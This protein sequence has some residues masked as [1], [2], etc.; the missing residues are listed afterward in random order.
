MHALLKSGLAVLV[1][2]LPLDPLPAQAGG[3]GGDRE[4]MP[5]RATSLE[6]HGI[7]WQ[8]AE[9]HVVGCFANGDPWVVGPVR[10]VAIE[11]SCVEVEGRVLHGSMVDPDPASML[12]GYDSCLFADEHRERYREELNAA[13]GISAE[14][15]LG[16]R[17]GQSLVSV[18]SRADRKAIP[19]LQGAAV[20]T[21]VATPPAPD[22]FRPP[23]VKGDKLM[24]HRAADLD[25]DV[26]RRLRPTLDA[27]PVES[28]AAGFERLW[29]DHF[30]NWPVRYAHPADN[31]PDY[32]REMAALVGSAGLLLNCDLPEQQKR[33]LLVRVVQ[34]GIDLHGALRGGCRW[35]GSGGHGSGRKFPIL[36]AG[37]VLHDG[38]ML[39][40]GREFRS[41]RRSA[42]EGDQY[43]A[44]DGQT[45]TVQETSPGVFNWGFGG[46]TVAHAGLPEWGFAH[47]D[48]PSG[49]RAEWGVDPYRRCC[50]ANGW[51]GQALA[52]RAMGLQEA[53][54]HP[55]FFDY[56]DRYMQVKHSDGWHRAWVPWHATMWDVHRPQH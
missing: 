34:L 30:P 52:A 2:A 1:W 46:Y 20:L 24:P 32:P 7:A 56:M 35:P 18:R 45:F 22:A 11:P 39:A 47:A 6:R 33:T 54:A 50:T 12:Q 23:C 29:L 27:P 42:D 13:W 43:F 16:L 44:E 26:L 21:V 17:P 9:P 15:P 25:F 38:R 3:A 5:A 53:W 55:A 40:A 8:F 48:Q 41:G 4:G 31:M 10:I 14:R 36:L 49:D 28:I 37:A 51:V 19:Q